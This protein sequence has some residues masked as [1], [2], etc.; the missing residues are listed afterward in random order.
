MTRSAG[1]VLNPQVG[2]TGA[3]WDAI[4][5]G[6]DLGV[7]DGDAW[8]WLHVNAIGVWAVAIGEDLDALNFHVAAAIDD[9]VEHLAV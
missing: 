4:I 5:A 3:N 2:G 8:R 9:D 1:N 6:L 7:E